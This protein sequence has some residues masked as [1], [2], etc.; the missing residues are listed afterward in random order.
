[1]NMY[2]AVV[3]FEG[4]GHFVEAAAIV[5]DFN[6]P[7][8]VITRNMVTPEELSILGLHNRMARHARLIGLDP[9]SDLHLVYS[10]AYPEEIEQ[11]EREFLGR[12]LP[13]YEEVNSM[14]AEFWEQHGYPDHHPPE[15][16][17][18]EDEVIKP[19]ENIWRHFDKYN[20]AGFILSIAGGPPGAEA[21]IRARFLRT[22]MSHPETKEIDYDRWNKLRTRAKLTPGFDAMVRQRP[23]DGVMWPNYPFPAAHSV[24]SYRGR[25]ARIFSFLAK[26]N[27]EYI[28]PDGDLI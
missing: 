10:A 28:D 11:K 17:I 6:D 13:G 14:V 2:G 24:R 7:K 21:M 8:L 3:E 1:M 9:H 12:V 5:L 16:I 25:Y 15:G 19:D 20:D 23:T 26:K 27:K 18:I 4:K 22:W